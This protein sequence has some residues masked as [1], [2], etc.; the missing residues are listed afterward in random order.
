MAM[1]VNDVVLAER[2]RMLVCTWNVGNAPAKPEEL[3]HWLPKAGEGLDLVVVGAPPL[4]CESMPRVA[5]ATAC[6]LG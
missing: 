5:R 4:P 2:L 6:V 3:S 1:E